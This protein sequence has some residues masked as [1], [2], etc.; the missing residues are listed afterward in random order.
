MYIY[1]IYERDYMF[2]KQVNLNV[3]IVMCDQLDE[4]AKRE[5]KPRS[6]VMREMLDSGIKQREEKRKKNESK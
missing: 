4:I 6:Y 3:P 1:M 2:M 5:N